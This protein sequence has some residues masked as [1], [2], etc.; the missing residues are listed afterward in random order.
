VIF[1]PTP[2]AGALLVEMEPRKDPRGWFARTW[3]AREFGAQ[4]L[5]AR[6]VQ[7]SASF[8]A[9]RG[10]L[11]GL[12]W[13]AAPH[14][15]AKLVRCTRGAIWDV[16]VDLRAGAATYTRHFAVELTQENGRAL[17]I[18]EGFAHGFVTLADDT[19]VFYQMTEYYEPAAARG[20]RWNDPAFGIPWPVT[21][22]ILHERDTRYPD[23]VPSG[24]A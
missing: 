16:I 17:F 21:T 9:R 4:G 1:T 5:D 20:A 18:P 2:L 3:C 15:E 19:E 13:Q 7:C 12:H 6:L 8:N 11:R 23:F 22:P 10:T 14:A 24:G